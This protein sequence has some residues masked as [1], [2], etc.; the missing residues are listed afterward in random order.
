MPGTVVRV[1]GLKRYFEPKTGRT[2]CYHRAS[3]KRISE[4]FGSPAFF[5]HLAQLDREVKDAAAV[6]ARPGTFEAV[7]LEYKLSDAFRDLAPRTR[8]D[9]EKVFTFLTP[10]YQ[11]RL[12]AFTTEQIVKL[13]NKWRQNRGRCFLNRARVV[14]SVLF[15]HAIEQ[16]WMGSNPVKDTKQ[17]KRPK[18]AATINRPWTL[19]ERK[20]VLEVMPPHLRL[21]IAIAL[22]S[23]MRMADVL[24]LTPIA[25]EGGM[26]RVKTAKRGVWVNLPIIPE[27]QRALREATPPLQQSMVAPLRLGL[28]MKGVPWTT[29]GFSCSFRRALKLLERQNCIGPGLTF[30]GL[31]HTV[32]SVLAEHGVSLEDIAAVLGQR[33]SQMA[34]HYSREADR[35]ARTQAAMSKYN[36]L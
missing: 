15:N 33:S 10:L 23:G 6:V 28:N 2:Y 20:V 13:R 18:D 4:E 31:R 5:A 29:S 32:A 36:P 30:H 24:K 3:G 22:C 11:A 25:I 8:V 12:S 26:I 19:K 17:I 16:G 14:L 9:C 27:L 1:K 7:I 21:P 34:A 35:S